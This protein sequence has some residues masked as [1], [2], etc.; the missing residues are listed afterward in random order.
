M[1]HPAI[2]CVHS[3]ASF[4]AVLIVIILCHNLIMSTQSRDLQPAVRLYVELTPSNVLRDYLGAFLEKPDE[5]S[6]TIRSNTQA[7][8]DGGKYARNEFADVIGLADAQLAKLSRQAILLSGRAQVEEVGNERRL[9]LPVRDPI[10]LHDIGEALR[11]IPSLEPRPPA[12]KLYWSF[13]V[14]ALA[15]DRRAANRAGTLLAAQLR[16]PRINPAM[17]VQNPRLRRHPIRINQTSTVYSPD[18]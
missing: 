11:N 14:E 13:A 7:V 16:G 8:V 1:R 4:H 17:W 12:T 15:N 9:C 18:D 2:T 5:A 3:W 6:Y 10:L